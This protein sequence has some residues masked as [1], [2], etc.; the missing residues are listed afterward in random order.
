MLTRKYAS[1]L[2]LL[3]ACAGCAQE[4]VS[5]EYH[6]RLHVTNVPGD[7]LAHVPVS[8]NGERIGVTSEDGFANLTILGREGMRANLR[9]EC[10]P[11][12]RQPT[13]PL[14][15]GLFDYASGSAPEI[16]TICEQERVRQ[17]VVV[18]SAGA[19]DLPFS[20]RGQAA[21]VTDSAG[22]AHALAEGA[23]GETVD[24]MFDTSAFPDLQPSNPSLRVV[25]G[26]HDD[27]M[28]AEQRFELKPHKNKAR[29]RS[30]GKPSR[31]AAAVAANGPVR[32]R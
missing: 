26:N 29:S 27:A 18:R 13:E 7:P 17:G 11:N 15:V 20:I 14:S 6:V 24:L 10:P 25:F 8:L 32:I 12:H 5:S 19:H 28:L 23:P 2:V 9:L 1:A 22:I 4:K 3:A 16:T 30:S 21:G 31:P